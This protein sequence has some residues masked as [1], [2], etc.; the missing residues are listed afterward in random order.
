MQIFSS[1]RNCY[2]TSLANKKNDE[3]NRC[4][5]RHCE[6]R[7]NPGNMQGAGLLRRLIMSVSYSV[8][9]TE[10]QRSGDISC[11]GK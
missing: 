3:G 8:M 11:V 9:S 4:A 2:K 5:C 7:S 6:E 1:L 10:A